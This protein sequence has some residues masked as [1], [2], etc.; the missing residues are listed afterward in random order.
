LLDK[1][2]IEATESIEEKWINSADQN[3][4]LKEV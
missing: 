1:H 4:Y 3:Y 2:M